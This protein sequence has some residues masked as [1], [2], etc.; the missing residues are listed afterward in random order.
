MT[1][2]QYL[3]ELGKRIAQLRKSKNWTQEDLSIKSGVERS[4]LARMESGGVNSGVLNLK[5]ISLAL[6]VTI[7]ELVDL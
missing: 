3:I 4:A 2:K 7:G 5:K 6:K 1:D